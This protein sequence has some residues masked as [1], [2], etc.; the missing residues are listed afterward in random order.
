MATPKEYINSIL[1]AI[2]EIA[3][4]EEKHQVI[5]SK[6]AEQLTNLDKEAWTTLE[7]LKEIIEEE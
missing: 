5:F 6:Y 4:L 1:E 3:A 2:K 7:T